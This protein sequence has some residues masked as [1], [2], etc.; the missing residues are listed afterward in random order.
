M[1]A[2]PR[3]VRLRCGMRAVLAPCEAESVAFGV[4]VKSGSRHET[5][6][7]AGISHFI[8]HM[9]FKGTPSRRA[10]DITC[11]IEG[12]GGNFN[13]FTGEEQ[14]CFF[15]H[16]PSECL[17]TAVE[18]LGD[19]YQNALISPDEFER[20]KGV[21]I[22]EIRM[23]QDEP[24]S[25]AA[26]NLQRAL[27]P[28]HPLGAPVAGTEASLRPMT[29]GMVKSY[30]RSHYRPSATCV[31]VAGAFDE[32]EAL[33]LLEAAFAPCGR[34]GGRVR[35]AA[36]DPGSP[37]ARPPV[38]ETRVE[39]EVAQVQLALGYRTFGV[40]DSRRYAATVLDAVLG[41]GMASRLF[42][43]VRERR[44][45]SYDI[46]SRLQFFSDAGQFTVSA[47]LERAKAAR[48]LATVDRELERVCRSKVPRAELERAKTYLIG[49]F[50]LAHEKVLSKMI[51]HGSAMTTFG[52]IVPTQEQVDGVRAVTADDVLGVARAIFRPEN[53]ALSLVV[54]K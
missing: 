3:V 23:Y 44:G 18:I 27:F 41:S 21:I 52:R 38:P 26:E 13:A 39:K 40:G 25:V 14:T 34:A 42:Q 43:S 31:V 49:N 28:G 35:R 7:T 1:T 10:Y 8:E 12:R 15:A 50:R 30:M 45:L 54:P 19:M 20:E 16:L 17:G 37:L 9:L 6:R 2:Q 11:A 22:E 48:A 36:A 24:D 47:G 4:F 46:S 32:G 29:P 53:R 5:A 33:R 51:Y